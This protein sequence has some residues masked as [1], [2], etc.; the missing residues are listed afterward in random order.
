MNRSYKRKVGELRH[1]KRVPKKRNKLHT[2][3]SA[4]RKNRK[5]RKRIGG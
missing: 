5:R 2:E 1:K 3:L 4:E